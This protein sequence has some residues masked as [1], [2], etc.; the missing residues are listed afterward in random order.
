MKFSAVIA[1]LAAVASAAPVQD[2]S[3]SGEQQLDKRAAVFKTTTFDDLSISGGNAGTAKEDAL[4]KLGGL[5]TDLKAVEKA[6]LTFLNAVNKIANNAERGAYNAKIAETA[7]G[8]DAL[9]LQRAKIQN[10]VLKLTATVLKLQA[11]QAQGKNVTAKLEEESKKLEKNIADDKANAGKPATALKFNAST[12]NPTASDVPKDETLAKKAGD[13]VDASIKAAGGGAGAGAA[14]SGT[15]GKGK[16]AGAATGTK[17]AKDAEK[18]G[19]KDAEKKSTK[20]EKTEK[21]EKVAV[22]EA[23]AEVAEEDEE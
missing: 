5:P 15:K 21:T 19:A 8:E 6:D 13:V 23:E 4:K 20:K 22:R 7:P 1:A 3:A 17:G 18:K 10:K 9:A 11:E 2:V 16:E 14:N 12:D